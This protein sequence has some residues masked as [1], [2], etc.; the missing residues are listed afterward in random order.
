VLY[1]WLS[2]FSVKRCWRRLFLRLF[3]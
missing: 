2:R 1:R 3:T